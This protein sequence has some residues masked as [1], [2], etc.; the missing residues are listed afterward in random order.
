MEP[1]A[2]SRVTLVALPSFHSTFQPL[3]Q[4]IC[5]DGDAEQREVSL[6]RGYLGAHPRTRTRTRTRASCPPARPPTDPARTHVG[7]GL[8]HV[9]VPALDGHKDR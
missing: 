2:S 4:G 6:G 5:G 1:R 9:A 8:Q 3:S 7:A